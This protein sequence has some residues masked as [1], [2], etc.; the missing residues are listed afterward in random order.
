MCENMTICVKIYFS[1]DIC[2]KIWLF[3][4]CVQFLKSCVQFLM[5]TILNP[6]ISQFLMK[7]KGDALS[8]RASCILLNGDTRCG[9][10]SPLYFICKK[11]NTCTMSYNRR[12]G[13][14]KHIN[15]AR[16]GKMKGDAFVCSVS[17]FRINVQRAT[18][19]VSPF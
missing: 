9:G 17:R 1:F 5:D 7:K 18:T 13:T 15:C 6:V 14:N 3:L 19:S 12:G 10:V 16:R 11:K 8:V 2:L 4:K